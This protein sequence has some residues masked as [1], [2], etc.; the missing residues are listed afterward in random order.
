MLTQAKR[1]LPER[2]VWVQF[3]TLRLIQFVSRYNV[4]KHTL[5]E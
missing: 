1:Q 2:P 4:G 5:K 3:K